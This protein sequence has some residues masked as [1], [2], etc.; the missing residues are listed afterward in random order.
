MS[1]M[2]HAGMCQ[3]WG[4]SSRFSGTKGEKWPKVCIPNT[5]KVLVLRFLCGKISGWTELSWRSWTQT[6]EFN[7]RPAD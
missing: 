7:L 6:D 3:S 2:F 5:R 1:S 4:Q